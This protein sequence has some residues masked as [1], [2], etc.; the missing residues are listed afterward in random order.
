MSESHKLTFTPKCVL[1]SE[2]RFKLGKY[3]QKAIADVF[4][5]DPAYIIWLKSKPWAQTDEK[6][7]EFIRGVNIPDICFGKHKGRTLEW[8]MQNDEEYMKYLYNSEWV[9]VNHPEL[10]AKVDKIY[11]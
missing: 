4:I 1:D 7:M 11:I 2:S 9:K 6:L 3:R 8:I 10:K 5:F